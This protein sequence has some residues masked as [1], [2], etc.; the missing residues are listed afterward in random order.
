MELVHTLLFLL[1]EPSMERD[2][3][4][5]EQCLKSLEKSASRT[6]MVF[7]QGIWSNEALEAYLSTFDLDCTVIGEGVNRGI[8][9]GRQSCFTYIWEHMPQTEF[10]TELH[11]DMIFTYRWETPLVDY[12]R[13]HDEPMVGCG[14]VDK[15]GK[16]SYLDLEVPVPPDDLEAAASYLLTLRRNQVV[17]GLNHPCVHRA[18][19]LQAVGGYDT[20]FLRNQQEFED[21][22]LMLGYHYYYGTRRNWRPKVCFRSV[23]FHEVAGQRLSLKAGSGPTN[24]GGLVKQYGAMGLKQLIPIHATPWHETFFLERFQ[25]QQKAD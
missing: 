17:N 1:R 5:A 7:N 9:I 24:F 3:K 14:I 13:D 11:M 19:I 16:L 18:D 8:V 4:R 2:L 15:A 10:I 22:S 25:Q 12:L 6:V 21:D 23:V 20:T